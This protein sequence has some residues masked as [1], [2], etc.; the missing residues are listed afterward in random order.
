MDNAI[1]HL[2]NNWGLRKLRDK[3]DKITGILACVQMSEKSPTFFVPFLHVKK[4][5]E[6]VCTQA[7]EILHRRIL[8][9]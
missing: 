9:S 4:K 8:F 3:T 7:T 5:V 1:I 2:W 6:D